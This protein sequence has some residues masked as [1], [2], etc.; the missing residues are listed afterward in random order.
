MDHAGRA[1]ALE[2][3]PRNLR[4]HNRS[5][6]VHRHHPVPV[7]V[8]HVGHAAAR[9]HACG[10]DDNVQGGER[11]ERTRELTSDQIAV[12]QVERKSGRLM[13]AGIQLLDDRRHLDVGGEHSCALGGKAA[14]DLGTLAP[15]SAGDEGG[16]AFQQITQL[17]SPRAQ[18]PSHSGS[19]PRDRSRRTH[20]RR[21]RPAGTANRQI[22][23]QPAGHGHRRRR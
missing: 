20:G 4:D 23:S 7:F 18:A 12:G 5:G 14:A 6:Q 8:V 9:Q 15:G 16:L 19:P 11:L 13:A 17:S 1:A 10:A 2:K 22:L 3:R 21:W